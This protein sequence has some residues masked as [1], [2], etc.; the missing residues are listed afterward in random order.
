MKRIFVLITILVLVS[1][2]FAIWDS[3]W[4]N[5]GLV[6]LLI[7]NDGRFGYTNAGIWP[8]GSGQHYIYG[9]GIW[10][11]AMKEIPED[12]TTLAIDL[13][14]TTTTVFVNSTANFAEAGAIKIED[15]LIYYR[16]TNDTSFLEC[17][18][19]FAKSVSCAHNLGVT[20]LGMS[21]ETSYGYNP[22]NGQTEYTPPDFPDYD[23]DSYRIYW[24]DDPA[25]TADWPLR[26][27]DGNP[28]IVSSQDSYCQFTDADS[29]R[30]T[31]GGF[32]LDIEVTQIGYSWYYEIYEDF[33]FI[34]YIIVNNSPDTLFYVHA[35]ICCDADVGDASDDLVDFD[36]DR[37]LG[38]AYDHDFNEP[39]WQYPPG[40]MGFDFLESPLDTAGEQ[41][42]LTAFKITTIQ[43]DPGDD[44][45]AYL[46]LAGYNFATAEYHPWDSISQEQDI[47]FVQCT[48]P[49]SLG[50]GDTAKVVIAVVAGEDM[51]DLQTN[52]DVAQNLYDLSFET[53]KVTVLYPNGGEEVDG[54]VSITWA[55]SSVT[56]NPLTVDILYSRDNGNTWD[57]L[58]SGIE[59]THEYEWNTLT[60]PDG[61]RYLIKVFVSDAITLGADISDA[62]FTINNPGNGVP[63]IILLS[64]HRGTVE[65]VVAVEWDAADADQDSIVI[66]ISLR[67]QD[68]E[69]WITISEGEENTGSYLWNTYLI[70]NGDYKLKVIAR[71][72][73][74]SSADSSD[75][76][77]KILNDHSPAG[78]VIHSNG[79]CNALSIQALEYIPEDY[80]GHTYEIRFNLIQRSGFMDPL[81]TYEFYDI[82][83]DSL[84]LTAQPLSTK[85]DGELYVDY[86]MIIDGFVLE[87]D[88]QIDLNFFRFVDFYIVTN[89]SGFDGNLEIDSPQPPTPRAW[90]FRGSDFEL[91]WIQYPD[92][93]TLI[94]LEVH[95]ITN[96]VFVPFGT[97]TGDSWYIGSG[98]ETL[99]PATDEKIHLCGGYFW[100]NE[101]G[102]MTTPP[103]PGDVWRINSAGPRVPCDGNVYTFTTIV[104]IE[105]GP[106]NPLMSVLYQN[107]PNPFNSET[108]ISYSMI[109]KEM[110]SLKVYD[111]AGRVVR[112]LVDNTQN[113]GNYN[114]R[115]DGKDD[116]GNRLASGIYFYRIDI[117]GFKSMRK[118][119]LLR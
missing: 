64:P 36:A 74:T 19:G 55:D 7:R 35:G 107:T 109:S 76:Y 111:L 47:R 108:A 71:D 51:P 5:K 101:D 63:D 100:F 66:D 60:V 22:S 67:R 102:T 21:M 14:D 46:L 6:E 58:T 115:W 118:M 30:H 39:G 116:K 16:T 87:L 15:E 114:I 69:E 53:H 41:L 1:P 11:G 3:G 49:F 119:I 34:T 12:T 38:Y 93:T 24:S 75:G 20:I 57:T 103:G 33:L 2:S 80:T 68:S 28:I 32:P 62:T 90:P 50:S 106:E 85:L 17:E 110:V 56:G 113:A 78:T 40:Y 26:D 84:L 42:G 37:D 43:T 104:G 13:D 27:D 25:D 112:T 89:V 61:T 9:A 79:G 94:S 88:S 81:Y 8:T 45:E 4:H 31:G 96:D 54:T 77:I 29:S 117:G 92:D 48:G 72:A 52:S 91:C 98:S 65:G 59:D 82:T 83:L 23:D 86:T 10:V 97:G 44:R 105:E 95:D 70:H 18:R 99:D 73:D